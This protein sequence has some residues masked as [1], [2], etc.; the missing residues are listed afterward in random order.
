MNYVRVC[1]SC[2]SQRPVHEMYCQNTVEDNSCGWLM[3]NVKQIP[4]GGVV[5]I[6]VKDEPIQRYCKN[7]HE[8]GSDDFMCM[9]C[10]ADI[11]VAPTSAREEQTL[12]KIDTYTLVETI[13]VSSAT[14]ECFLV[15]NDKEQIYFLTLYHKVPFTFAI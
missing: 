15:K 1:P 7:G 10:G 9:L 6:K 3:M 8:I 11:A 13:Q 4:I 5:E 14:K 12:Q 2:G